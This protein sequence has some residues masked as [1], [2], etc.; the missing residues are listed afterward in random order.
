VVR[1]RLVPCESRGLCPARP[2]GAVAVHIQRESPDR[3]PR[4]ARFAFAV[5]LGGTFQAILDAES[6]WTRESRRT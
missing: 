1:G 6:P 2:A 4:G 5:C 3:A